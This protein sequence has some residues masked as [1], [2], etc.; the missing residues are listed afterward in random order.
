[1]VSFLAEL[2]KLRV[3]INIHQRT[4]RIRHEI[5]QSSLLLIRGWWC[6]E[7]FPRAFDLVQ[8]VQGKLL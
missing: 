4:T 5:E 1:M 3:G 7:G 2:N 8:G 6:D